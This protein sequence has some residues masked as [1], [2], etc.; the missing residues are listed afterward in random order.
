MGAMTET[1]AALE[2]VSHFF[3]ELLAAVRSER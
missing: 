1:M 3:T 2:V